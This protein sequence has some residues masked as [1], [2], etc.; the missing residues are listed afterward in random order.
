MS[1]RPW[2]ESGEAEKESSVRRREPRNRTPGVTREN[3]W[4]ER[5]RSE[6]GINKTMAF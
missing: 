3:V 4:A 2:A 1:H 5:G 6:N